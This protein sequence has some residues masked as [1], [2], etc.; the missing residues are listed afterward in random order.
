MLFKK[1]FGFVASSLRTVSRG[2]FNHFVQ[3]LLLIVPI[4][5]SFLLVFMFFGWVSEFIGKLLAFF[6]MDIPVLVTVLGINIPTLKIFIFLI[7][8]LLI[9]LI[10]AFGQTVIAAPLKM[11]F[12][13]MIRKTPILQPIYSTIS[14]FLDAFV[15][16][17][18]KFKN[19][20]L[21]TINASAQVEKIGFIT[22]SDLSELS[23]KDKVGVFCPHSYNVSGDFFI[24]PVSR[25]RP[26]DIPASEAMKLA[27][28]GGI[29]QI[30]DE[31]EEDLVQNEPVQ[32]FQAEVLQTGT[33]GSAK[34]LAKKAPARRGR[35]RA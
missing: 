29:T 35:G 18:R 22:Q 4:G 31:D 24:V 6:G 10:G 8:V 23:I 17:K 28:T 34:A 16:K 21:V 33:V 32:E 30:P 11:M 1:M 27:W 3:G 20:V 2:L 19:P 14:D 15:G 5:L 25:V 7:L 12:N 13:R 26:L 9:A